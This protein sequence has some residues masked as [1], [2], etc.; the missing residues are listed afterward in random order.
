MRNFTIFKSL[1]RRLLGAAL[2]VLLV[3]LLCAPLVQADSRPTHQ[4]PELLN[5]EEVELL[6]PAA[7]DDL[8]PDALR[9]AY[10]LI[11]I[12]DYLRRANQN[13]ASLQGKLDDARIEIDE[14]RERMSTIRGQIQ[15][16]ESLIEENESKIRNVQEQINE[17]E[18]EIT[19]SL[20]AL[21]FNMVQRASQS[22]ALEA[23]LRLL[24]FEKNIY[25]DLQNQTNDLKIL[26]QDETLSEAL[27]KGTYLRILEDE[28]RRVMANLTELGGK[29]QSRTK[30][31]T[32]KRHQLGELREDLD[33]AHRDLQAE[34][35]GK[36]NLLEQIEGN[37]ALYRELY[38]SYKLAQDVVIN[39]IG[40]FHNNMRS[41]DER[42][43]F[44]APQLT[45]DDMAEIR[46]IKSDADL[47]FSIRDAAGFLGL[48][49]PV[50]P[51]LGLTAYFDDAGYVSTFGVPHHALDVRI[52][53]GTP[54]HAP[55]DGIV[56]KVNDTAA[57][58][59]PK[60]RLKYGYVIIAH[61]KGVMTLYGH[62]SAVLVREGDFV[63]RGQVVGLTGGTPGTPGAG[64][65]T[66]GAHLHME[67]FQDGVR[68]DPMEYLPI[69]EIPEGHWGD[70]PGEYLT[71]IEDRLIRS[72]EQD[73]IREEEIDFDAEL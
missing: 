54:I 60:E 34:I 38:A 19:D 55:A 17:R 49:W 24:Y 63:K 21:E 29:I 25:F 71:M 69:E 3:F 28:S 26:L 50:S 10:L 36:S 70:L 40:E 56:Y 52:S 6:Y 59:D 13:Y 66:T 8:S 65:R 31:L 16:L 62:T 61:R 12:Q 51:R 1:N 46:A 73:G 22:Q 72:L 47:A 33:G 53:H 23:Y 15:H 4:F 2:I 9:N 57:L 43:A 44:L 67:V 5:V 42:L 41:L 64:G 32:L 48:N 20:E 7:T 37:D 11:R 58:E 68:V 18:L 39:E 14:N 30:E 27:Q 45:E 35:Q